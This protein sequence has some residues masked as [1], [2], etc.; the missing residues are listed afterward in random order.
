MFVPFRKLYICI[1]YLLNVNKII[2]IEIEKEGRIP[3]LNLKFPLNL[4]KG[5]I[6]LNNI[7]NISIMVPTYGPNSKTLKICYPP[8]SVLYS[9]NGRS[10]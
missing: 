10:L 1:H 5:Y 9:N 2:E 8:L 7:H 3:D 6:K 4:F